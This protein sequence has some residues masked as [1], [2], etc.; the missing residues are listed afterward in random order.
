MY[1]ILNFFGCLLF[2][3]V[4]LSGRISAVS[5]PRAGFVWMALSTLLNVSFWVIAGAAAAE[6]PHSNAPTT[7]VRVHTTDLWHPITPA[8]TD[9]G[10]DVVAL[11]EQ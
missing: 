6:P 7:S 1:Q 9:A 10:A 5:V 4:N 3:R 2:G 8:F 11:R